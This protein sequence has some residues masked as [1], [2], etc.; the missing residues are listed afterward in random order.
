MHAW[1]ETV[2]AGFADQIFIYIAIVVAGHLNEYLKRLRREERERYRYQQALVASQ[3]HSLKAQLRLTFFSTLS[4]ESPHSGMGI[5][6][7]PMP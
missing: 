2:R 7:M 4:I 3:L 6:K 5:R 1:L